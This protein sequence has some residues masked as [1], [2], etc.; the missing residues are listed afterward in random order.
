MMERTV[1]NHTRLQPY[2]INQIS[3]IHIS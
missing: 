2:G 3:R 1:K